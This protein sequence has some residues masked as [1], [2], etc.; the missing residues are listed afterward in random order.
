MRHNL[1]TIGLTI[2]L[3]F[4]AGCN[5]TPHHTNVMVFGTN[6]KFGLDAAVNPAGGTPDFTLGY[7][8]Q[9]VVWMPLLA[10]SNFNEN[11]PKPYP[12]GDDC[13]FRGKDGDK[14]LDTYSVLA[15]FGAE[16]GG[17]AST[18]GIDSTAAGGSGGLAQFFATGLAARNLAKEG[19]YRLVSI[20]GVDA[21]TLALANENRDYRI[22]EEKRIEALWREKM[23][24]DVYE[25]TVNETPSVQATLAEKS[26]AILA[27][28]TATDQTLNKEA[29]SKLVA[30]TD[31]PDALKKQLTDRD[32][33]EKVEAYLLQEVSAADGGRI[34]PLH[35]QLGESDD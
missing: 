23:G 12:C 28:V 10:N 26:K 17:R 31:L 14:Q 1:S 25:Q 7:K 21:D 16:F 4:I 35:N 18:N 22:A 27:H 24:D 33:L 9:E 15:S 11:L 5:S 13:M 8:R 20:Q 32:T 3:A 6:T 29:W 30:G 2:T 19:G 34:N